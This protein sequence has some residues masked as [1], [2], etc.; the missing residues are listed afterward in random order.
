[1]HCALSISCASGMSRRRLHFSSSLSIL[2]LKPNKYDKDFNE[3]TMLL[4]HV[5]PCYQNQQNQQQQNTAAAT[6]SSAAGKSLRVCHV[7]RQLTVT[8]PLD[9]EIEINVGGTVLCVPRK[10]LLLPGVSDSFIAYLLLHHLDGLP[11]DTEGRPF[12]D[13]DPI[14][15][16]WLFNEIANVGVAD[17]QAETHEIKLTGDHSTDSASLFWHEILFANKTDLNITRQDRQDTAIDDASST[18][19]P[20]NALDR[21]AA[22]VEKALDDIKT[23]VQ[24]VM[25]EHQQLLKFHRVMGPFLKSADGKGNEIRSVRVMGRTVSTTE[26]TLALIGTDKRPTPLSTTLG[27]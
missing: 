6:N 26:S 13:A 3:L 21:S 15:M 10:P 23:A 22:S 19:T 18:G 24:Q 9:G 25:D 4:T 16:D 8:E 12:L 20:L 7:Y 17:A 11:K 1:M 2:R 14:Y 5:T 27:R